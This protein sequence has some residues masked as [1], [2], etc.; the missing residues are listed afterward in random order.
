M[1]EF[2]A[3][4][5]KPITYYSHIQNV[6]GKIGKMFS[7]FSVRKQFVPDR[8]KKYLLLTLSFLYME[9]YLSLDAKYR[10]LTRLSMNENT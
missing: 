4:M 9:R 8:S 5:R 10:Y 7:G 2:V 3:S 6:C 1:S